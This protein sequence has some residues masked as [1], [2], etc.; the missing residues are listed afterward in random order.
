MS[1]PM[2]GS[3][4]S[5]VPDASLDMPNMTTKRHRLGSGG[6]LLLLLL[7]LLQLLL[8]LIWIVR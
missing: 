6:Y 8:L 2:F 3:R 5:G 1:V 7:L 4:S